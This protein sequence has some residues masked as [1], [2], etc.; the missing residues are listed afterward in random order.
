M[1]EFNPNLWA[2]WRMEYIRSLDADA[3]SDTGC[4]LCDYAAAPAEDTAHHVIWR[5]ERVFVMMNRFPYTNGHLLI[6][7]LR[8]CADPLALESDELNEL[9]RLTY[10]GV[11]L[12]RRTLHAEGFNVGANLGRCA[13]AGLPDHLHH[14]V[15]ARWTGD[16][17][18]MAV[19]GGTRVIP[20]GLDATYA[21]LIAEAQKMGLRD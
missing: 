8:H 18:Y 9:T 5:G 16:T 13:G 1:A 11:E 4:F 15:V 19:L 7:P 21:Q 14:H 12:L 6:A 10:L 20:D 3:R 2:P 17:N